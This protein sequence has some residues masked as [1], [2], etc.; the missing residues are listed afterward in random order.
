MS[1]PQTQKV[2]LLLFQVRIIHLEVWV[3]IL[4]CFVLC[5]CM[6]L[7]L[8]KHEKLS[9]KQHNC[10]ACILCISRVPSRKKNILD[11]GAFKAY[12]LWRCLES[13]LPW[14]PWC[15]WAAWP[16]FI[17]PKADCWPWAAA[18]RQPRHSV[19]LSWMKLLERSSSLL[20]WF[21]ILAVMS[22]V[23]WALGLC[24]RLASFC[25]SLWQIRTWQAWTCC[26]LQNICIFWILQMVWIPEAVA[27]IPIMK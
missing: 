1:Y 2:L 7:E 12:L 23:V 17:W 4:H 10:R 27:L 14:S 5:G 18:Q 6:W 11:C 9:P 24:I 22:L 3:L 26:A 8:L 15:W 16:K 20:L 19:P 13:F 21:G 25:A